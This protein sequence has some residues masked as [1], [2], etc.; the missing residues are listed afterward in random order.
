MD[1]STTSAIISRTTILV[2]FFNRWQVLPASIR[3]C[4]DQKI[5][6]SDV[7]D[8]RVAQTSTRCVSSMMPFPFVSAKNLL[9]H[10]VHARR[11]RREASA[12]DWNELAKLLQLQPSQNRAE[13]VTAM[14]IFGL[15]NVWSI[16][17]R[18]VCALAVCMSTR[19]MKR[20]TTKTL[21]EV[22]KPRIADQAQSLSVNCSV[23]SEA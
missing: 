8:G 5:Q 15:R 3:L 20:T 23:V 4:W 10:R 14:A 16:A 2:D 6:L 18:R 9:L 13:N 17:M 19:S 7:N 12:L 11:M 21:E 1:C 22:G